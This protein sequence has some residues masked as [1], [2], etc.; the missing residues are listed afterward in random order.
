MIFIL[1]C[2]EKINEEIPENAN[3]ELKHLVENAK[4]EAEKSEKEFKEC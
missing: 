1:K 3:Q 2:K 4:M